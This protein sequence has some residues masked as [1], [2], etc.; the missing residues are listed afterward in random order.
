MVTIEEEGEGVAAAAAAAV[1]AEGEED[2]VVS[3][4]RA[5]LQRRKNLVNSVRS[6]RWSDRMLVSPQKLS[7]SYENILHLWAWA[8]RPATVMSSI[9]WL[10]M[11]QLS[12]HDERAD[13]KI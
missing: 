13:T 3:N 2:V 5:L 9:T 12:V 8:V 11:E 4:E 1:G 10:V 6:R 7:V